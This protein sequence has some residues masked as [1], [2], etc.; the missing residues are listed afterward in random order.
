MAAILETFIPVSD[1]DR[2]KSGGVL[3]EAI[4]R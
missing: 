4:A 1:E 2:K 3:R